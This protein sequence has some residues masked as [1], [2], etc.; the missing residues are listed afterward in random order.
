MN[1]LTCVPDSAPSCVCMEQAD[2]NISKAM[3]IKQYK[4]PPTPKLRPELHTP[5]ADLKQHSKRFENE[6]NLGV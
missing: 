3:R 5:R 4:P 6:A 1:K 2:R